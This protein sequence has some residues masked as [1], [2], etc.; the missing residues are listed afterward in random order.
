MAKSQHDHEVTF[1][2]D[3]QSYKILQEMKSAGGFDS[4]ALTIREALRIM[5]TLQQQ[6]SAGFDQVII[7][8]NDGNQRM[9]LGISVVVHH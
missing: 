9:L 4:D 3:P 6:A 7:Q 8:N 2:F 1:A 5:R